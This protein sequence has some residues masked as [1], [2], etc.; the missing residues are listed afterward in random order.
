MV[1]GGLGAGSTFQTEGKGMQVRTGPEEEEA[2]PSLV[3]GVGTGR[4]AGWGG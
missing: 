4:G 3:P 2:E 1:R